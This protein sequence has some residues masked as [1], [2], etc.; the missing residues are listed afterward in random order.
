MCQG[1]LLVQFGK[2]KKEKIKQNKRNWDIHESI[3]VYNLSLNS[4]DVTQCRKSRRY[5]QLS[6]NA[7]AVL[8]ALAARL[9]ALT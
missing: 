1:D 6:Y 7:A 9:P 2:C 3:Q 5:K 4:R 8:I